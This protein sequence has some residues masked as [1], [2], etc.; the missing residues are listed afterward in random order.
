VAILNQQLTFATMPADVRKTFFGIPAKSFLP[1]NTDLYRFL[2]PCGWIP[3]A[4]MASNLADDPFFAGNRVIS[5]CFIDYETFTAIPRFARDS[6]LTI[7]QVAQP[8]LGV[9]PAWNPIMSE[10]GCV[11]LQKPVYGFKGACN[12]KMF[13]RQLKSGGLDQI[14]IPNLTTDI[15]HPVGRNRVENL[16]PNP[17]AFEP[18]A[19]RLRSY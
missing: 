17:T 10:F 19:T 16:T 6:G 3:D 11:R 2:S 18:S 14:W 15:A 8:A 9:R 12:R 7:A 13:D 5:D 1:E 4:A